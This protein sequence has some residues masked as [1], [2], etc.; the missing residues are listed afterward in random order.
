[1]RRLILALAFLASPLAGA[2][3]LPQTVIPEHYA[4][5]IAPDL[6]N[7]TFSGEETIDVDVKEPIDSITMHAVDLVLRDVTINQLPAAV[8]FDAPNETVTLKV[9][10]TIP[11][12]RGAIR[13][14]FDGKLLPQL[15]GLYLSRTAK[16]KYAATQFEAMSARRAFPCFDE[17]AMKAIYDVTLVVDDGDTA[18]S[19]GAIVSDTTA[20]NGKHAIRFAMTKRMSTYLLAFLVGDFQCISGSADGTPIRVCSTPGLQQL[21]GFALS[22]AQN[23][24]KFFNRYYDIQYPF[25]KLD[26]ISIPDFAAGAMENAGAITFR[27]TDLLID[28]RT[29]SVLVQKRVAEVVAHEIAHQWFGDLVTMEWWN[30]IW[31]NEGFATFMS[32]KPIEVWKPEWR[33]DLDKP[34]QTVSALLVDS[35]LST[36][37]IRTPQAAEGGGMFDA[38]ITYDKTASVLR[39]V[40]EWIG[41]EAFRRAISTYL[42]KYAW[43]NA[44]AEDFWATMKASSQQPIDAVLQSFIDLTGPPLLHVTE[45]CEANG[46][47][48]TITQERMVPRGATAP[49]QT[50]TIPICMTSC[51][52]I[53]Q[54]AQTFPLPSTC[55]HPLFL[56]RNGTGYF[57]VDYPENER[58]L[59][60][61]HL[62]DL[63]PS[64]RI[65]FHGNEW[66]LLR[67]N[68]RDAGEYLALL[69]AM[70][71][72]A[73]RQ[74]ATAIADN[75]VWL[76]QRLVDDHNRDAWR[77]FVRQVLPAATWETLPGETSEQRIAR[78]Y[79][80]WT[81]GYI[82]DAEVIAGARRVAEQYMKD[83]S[84][85]DALLADRSLRLSAVYGDEA[86]FNGVVEQLEKAPNPEIA[87]RY[88]ALLPLFRDPKLIARAIDYIYSDRVRTQDLPI[89][90]AAMFAEPATRPAAWAAAKSRWADIE[91]RS[92]ATLGRIAASASFCD[93]ESKKD[94]ESF[95]AAHPLRTGQRA[96]SR[97][98]EAIDTCIAFRAAQQQSF[99][100]ALRTSS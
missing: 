1:M 25:D 19:N 46:R 81:F 4:I 75:L 45:T 40:E 68:R 32:Q 90:V 35:Q 3:R 15:R 49:A 54:P 12:G 78:A 8:T 47:Q 52:V 11:P 91:K 99:D 18:I 60:R 64:E 55:D 31:L 96:L 89:V 58:T 92:P 76:D 13:I 95:F 16:R 65:S 69:R 29:A 14:A 87:N 73:E 85:V 7:E 77:A 28:E 34:A 62:R 27:E 38:A 24:V 53:A 67:N 33:A 93:A 30:D 82:G 88:R 20:G 80:L 70:P 79:T 17:P 100:L 48:V 9:S 6:Q 51:R 50:W 72:P 94:V 36:R 63:A 61:T 57:L 74:I 37:P 98:I 84:S 97:A 10:Q 21:G 86:F 56:S 42:K 23:S 66:L 2:T 22:A 43:S 26:L 71:R 44:A 59:L 41:R 39:M 5:R 83:P